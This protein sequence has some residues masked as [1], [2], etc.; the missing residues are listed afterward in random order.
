MIVDPHALGDR[1]P[2]AY[3]AVV[4]STFNGLDEAIAMLGVDP[5]EVHPR[6]PVASVQDALE[7]YAGGELDALSAVSVL[8]PGGAFHQ[9]GWIAMRGI[10]AGSTITYAELARRS[11]NAAAVRAAGNTCATNRVAP[12]V[13]CHR[14]LASNGSLG[15]YAYGLDLKVALLEHEGVLL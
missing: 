4:A 10:P 14:V 11:G 15:G 2:T 12:F 1:G 9:R 7:R 13:P 5:Q 3:G 8:Q 6:S